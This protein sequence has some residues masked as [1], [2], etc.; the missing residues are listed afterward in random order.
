M[1]EVVPFMMGHQEPEGPFHDQT[2][3]ANKLHDFAR[4]S[5]DAKT[6]GG[7]FNSL[8][9]PG[10]TREQTFVIN[11]DASF[12]QTLESP[13]YS[14]QLIVLR[15]VVYQSPDGSWHETA[16]ACALSVDGGDHRIAL[17]NGQFDLSGRSLGFVSHPMAD[18]YAN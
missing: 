1:A 8:L 17:T 5:L 16:E 12:S 11:K 14:G 13:R 2:N 18:P 7:G 9:F 15:C 3:I 10:D 4:R 6:G